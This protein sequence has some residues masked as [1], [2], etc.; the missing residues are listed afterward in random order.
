M[1]NIKNEDI[2]KEDNSIGDFYL[3]KKIYISGIERCICK[4]ETNFKIGNEEKFIRGSGFFCNIKE[5]KIKVFMTNNHVCNQE[6]LDNAKKLNYSIEEDFMKKDYQLNLEKKRYKYTDEELDFTV[7]EILKEDKIT[8]F[9]EIDEFINCK[10]Y[11]NEKIVILQYPQSQ[12]LKISDGTIKSKNG[13]KILYDVGTEGG[14]SGS[15]LILL[16]NLKIIGLH[17]GS[18]Y[19]KEEKKKNNKINIGIPLNLIINKIDYIKGDNSWSFKTFFNIFSSEKEMKN[20]KNENKNENKINEDGS[21]KSEKNEINVDCFT[22]SK[23]IEINEDYFTESEKIEINEDYFTKSEK[24]EI[25]D[26][27]ITEPEKIRRCK[28]NGFILV[29]NKGSGKTTLLNV[30][31]GKEVGKVGKDKSIITKEPRIYYY[32]LDNRVYISLI[33]TPGIEDVKLNE[34]NFEN[35]IINILKEGIVLKG[36]LFLSNYLIGR[37]GSEQLKPLIILN[38]IF[39]FIDFRK[40]VLIIYTHY[41]ED[42]EYDLEENEEMRRFKFDSDFRIITS[43]IEGFSEIKDYKEI[44]KKYFNSY[45]PIKRE[46]QEYRNREVRKEL[47]KELEELVNTN[48]SEYSKIEFVNAYDY[49][50]I[51]DDKTY[52]VDLEIIRFIPVNKEITRIFSKREIN[53]N[54]PKENKIRRKIDLTICSDGEVFK[55]KDLEKKEENCLLF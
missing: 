31:F 20:E 6:F 28:K 34:K 3:N 46:K 15:P 41:F 54:D 26:N 55:E 16:D 12:N 30:L 24:I 32:L 5:K 18:I 2:I 53:K 49:K 22:E 10:D 27:G 35:M 52:L 40:Y 23:K 11:V 47:E 14:S 17:Q 39:S 4:I 37:L 33:E 19:S 13:N 8:N 7:I 45:W 44:K 43:K 9:L 36:I 48:I 1:E 42:P 38:K 50:Y 25:I 51:E 29:G 21:T